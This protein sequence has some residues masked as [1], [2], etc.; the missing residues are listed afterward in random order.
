MLT[1]AC[2]DVNDTVKNI[3]KLDSQSEYY[4]LGKNPKIWK[5]IFEKK[6][7]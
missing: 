2:I 5:M 4:C 3:T 6:M 7:L 1:K